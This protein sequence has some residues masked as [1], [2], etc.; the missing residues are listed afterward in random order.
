MN[1]SDSQSDLLTDSHKLDLLKTLSSPSEPEL[2]KA[3]SAAKKSPLLNFYIT[4]A[5]CV[6]RGIPVKI[7]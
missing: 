7:T 3:L 2:L 6:A 5:A 4:K 1:F